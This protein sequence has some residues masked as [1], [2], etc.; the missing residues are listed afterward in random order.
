MGKIDISL[1]EYFS[2]PIRYADLLNGY[3]FQGRQKVK[4]DDVLEKDSRVTGILGKFGSLR[5]RHRIQKYRDIVRRIVFGTHIA[6]IG[7]EHQ[8]LIHRAMPVRILMEDAA[9]YDEQLRKIQKHHRRM[10]DLHGDEYVGGFSS[11]DYL[12]PILTIVIYWGEDS[13]TGPKNLHELMKLD[14]FPEELRPYINNYPIYVLDVR[15][16]PNLERFQSDI[17]EVFGFVQTSKDT[18]ALFQFVEQ[19]REQF[20]KLQEDA[21]DLIAVLT[22]SAELAENKADHKNEGGTFNMCEGL[23]GLIEEGRQEGLADG[24]RQGLAD[25]RRQG[26]A[27]G[28]RQGLADGLS[29]KAKTVARNMFLRGMSADDAAAI[30]EEDIDLIRSWFEEWTKKG[31]K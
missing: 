8:Q 20:E 9:G 12:N 5:K 22:G 6:I 23:R 4:P 30:C 31:C 14:R 26:L 2:D 11:Q 7:L 18:Q 1:A 15:T 13:W 27:D 16:C 10:R 19:H 29:S 28:R 25:G 24:W 21:Y 3:I 17:R